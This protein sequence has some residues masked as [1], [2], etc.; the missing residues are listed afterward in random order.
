MS[1]YF[2]SN[3]SFVSNLIFSSVISAVN[4]TIIAVFPSFRIAVL[5][6][7][8]PVSFTLHPVSSYAS[9]IAASVINS[10]SSTCPAEK[11]HCP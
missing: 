6:G 3:I 11:F 10:F 5:I 2:T 1:N 9:L 4:F 7:K 8:T